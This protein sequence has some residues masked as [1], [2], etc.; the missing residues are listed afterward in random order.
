MEK[1]KNEYNATDYTIKKILRSDPISK[2]YAL[3]KGDIVRII[4]PSPT[5]GEAI[6]YRIVM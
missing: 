3:R 2:Y 1:F 6:D 4:R 5:S